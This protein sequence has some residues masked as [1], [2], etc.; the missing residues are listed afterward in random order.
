MKNTMA[1]VL[2]LSVA[3][4]NASFAGVPPADRGSGSRLEAFPDPLG[5]M[6]TLSTT[7]RI[8]RRN[9]FFQV[10]GTNG[11]TCATC[12]AADQ[13][14]GLSAAVARRTF[15]KTRGRDPLF[16]PVDGTNCPVA[17][18]DDAAAHSLLLGYGLFRFAMPLPANAEFTVS[19]V[20]DPYGC[21]MTVDSQTGQ[22]DIAVYPAVA[23]HQSRLPERRDVR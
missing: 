9:P 23:G 7:G 15:R 19:V 12:H 14:F 18:R 11:R 13:A 3:L 17:R 5:V 21:A 1:A 22:V 20:H 16:A 2:G 8:D 4:G 6:E 10:L